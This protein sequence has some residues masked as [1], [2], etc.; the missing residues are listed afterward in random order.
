[1]SGTVEISYDEPSGEMNETFLYRE[2]GSPLMLMCARCG[3]QVTVRDLMI[4]ACGNLD[5]RWAYLTRGS[6]TRTDKLGV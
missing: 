2:N 1:M 6:K 5:Y 3:G 4:C